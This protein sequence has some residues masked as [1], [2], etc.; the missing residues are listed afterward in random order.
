MKIKAIR[1]AVWLKYKAKYYY[2]Q[3]DGMKKVKKVYKCNN[4][5]DTGYDKGV[6]CVCSED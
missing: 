4:C 3:E 5:R 2:I 1:K 6:K